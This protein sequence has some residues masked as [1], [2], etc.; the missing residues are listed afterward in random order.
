MAAMTQISHCTGV[1]R[2]FMFLETPRT[3]YTGP[4]RDSDSHQGRAA[5]VGGLPIPLFDVAGVALLGVVWLVNT[6]A[7]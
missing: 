4:Q 5:V 2:V 6:P 7:S 3:N 1:R